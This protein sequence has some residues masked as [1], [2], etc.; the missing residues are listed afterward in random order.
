MLEEI[1]CTV[2]GYSTRRLD[3]LA[4]NEFTKK[5]LVI[6]PTIRYEIMINQPQEIKKE[7][8][9]KPSFDAF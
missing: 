9:Y 1:H 3:I 5:E 6:D 8:I 2:K 4:Y 7:N